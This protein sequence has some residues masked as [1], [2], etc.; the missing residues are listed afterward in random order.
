MNWHPLASRSHVYTHRPV[1]FAL[2][3]AND[4]YIY[5]MYIWVYIGLSYISRP[6]SPIRNKIMMVICSAAQLDQA[7]EEMIFWTT[8]TQETG[9]VHGHPCQTIATL[10]KKVRDAA[11]VCQQCTQMVVQQLRDCQTRRVVMRRPKEVYTF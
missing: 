3:N 6:S 10:V 11:D 1:N 5:I 7:R 9:C 8:R 2:C 4:I